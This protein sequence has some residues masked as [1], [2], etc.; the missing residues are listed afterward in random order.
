MGPRQRWGLAAV[1]KLEYGYD[2]QHP[3]YYKEIA[4]Y[5]YGEGIT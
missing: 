2:A 1:V 5:T 4:R 3:E